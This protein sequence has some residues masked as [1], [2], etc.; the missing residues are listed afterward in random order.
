VQPVPDFTTTDVT[1]GPCGNVPTT[2]L[3]PVKAGQTVTFDC[4]SISS[5]KLICVAHDFLQGVPGLPLTLGK[6]LCLLNFDSALTSTSPVMTYIASCGSAD[7][8]SFKGDSGN[9]WVKID[10][11]GYNHDRTGFPWGKFA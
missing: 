6:S 2:A 7:C 1:C 9:V 3:A 10:Q 4:K 8:S 11:D 5:S